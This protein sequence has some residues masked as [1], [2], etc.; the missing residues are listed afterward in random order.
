ML[1]GISMQRKRNVYKRWRFGTQVLEASL[2]SHWSARGYLHPLPT[3]FPSLPV[4]GAQ[5]YPKGWVN[6]ED[7]RKVKAEVSRIFQTKTRE[8]WNKIFQNYDCCVEVVPE[9]EDISQK[10][11]QLA[12]RELDVT[13]TIDGKGSRKGKSESL[14]VPKMPLNMKYG[15]DIQM[16]KGPGL[17]EHNKELLSKL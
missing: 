2:R 17:G 11:K 7:C 3:P 10:D 14:R 4:T 13:I 6:G 16:K 12:A 5:L 15:M 8:E 1:W 9:V